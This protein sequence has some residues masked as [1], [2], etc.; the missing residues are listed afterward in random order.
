MASFDLP[1]MVPASSEETAEVEKE[2]QMSDVEG[3]PSSG[4]SASYMSSFNVH[5]ELYVPLFEDTRLMRSETISTYVFGL[6]EELAFS[7]K[8]WRC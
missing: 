6:F 7:I 4:V 5:G 2:L 8:L 1:F 3:S